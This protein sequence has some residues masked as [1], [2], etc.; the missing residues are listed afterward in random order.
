MANQ[1]LLPVEKPSRIQRQPK[2]KF[3]LESKPMQIVPFCIAQVLPGETL[4]NLY[5]ETRAVTDPI[6]NPLIGWS[7]EYYF[8]Y[9]KITDFLVDDLKQMFID[10]DN[11]TLPEADAG[12]GQYFY[13]PKGGYNYLYKAYQKIVNHWFRDEGEDFDD[14]KIGSV[15]AGAQIRD[16]GF[17]DS[18]TDK[19]DMPEG[20]DVADATTLGDLDRLLDLFEMQRALGIRDMT[21][22]DFL[23]SN[24]IAV[25]DKDEQKPE[26][27]YRFSDWQYPSNT[28]D[29]T[30]GTPRSAVSWVFK[31]GNR[32]PKRFKE[33]GFVI[34]L[35]VTRPKFYMSG[36]MGFASAFATRAWDWMPNYLRS[37]PETSL[38]RFAG[39]TGPLGDR[40]T[41]PD[42]YWL[43]MNDLLI[44]GDQFQNVRS[45]TAVPAADG[46]F[47]MVPLPDSD[48]NSFNTKYV[49]EAMVDAL[50]V[51][52]TKEMIREDGV[53]TLT[54]DGFQK[55]TTIGN[56]A[57]M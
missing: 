18:L 24:G 36:L 41:A 12:H 9:I 23:R 29:P 45:F 21:Y 44:H 5:F 28:I 30:N 46:T 51:S 20:E 32:S 7:K 55:D 54:V 6:K 31:N 37:M 56:F 3:L 17:L 34:G 27:L 35:T 49:S 39:D 47:N 1:L 40:T 10:P 42:A 38:K 13:S 11:A 26:L 48:G 8:F 22:E 53:V 2:H 25:P 15:Y 50:F 52:D 33:P 57:Q 19:D 4:K 14:Y 43:D 16:I